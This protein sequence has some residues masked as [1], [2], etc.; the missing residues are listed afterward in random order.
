[1]SRSRQGS[2]SPHSLSLF[3]G[4][5]YWSRLRSFT[6]SVS[7]PSNN[8]ILDTY[9]TYV[10]NDEVTNSRLYLVLPIDDAS[11]PEDALYSLD[12]AAHFADSDAGDTRTYSLSGPAWLSIDETTGLLS[13]TPTNTELATH[14][15]TVTATAGA[16]LSISDTFTLTVTN[17]NDAPLPWRCRPTQSTR[18]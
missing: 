8:A 12:V 10:L 6:L 17:V 18:T 16:G 14:T 2:I 13:G 1:M 9:Q 15:L 4:I 3:P 11:T 5:Q 7:N